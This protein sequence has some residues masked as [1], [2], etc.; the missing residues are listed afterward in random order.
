MRCR[1]VKTPDKTED[2]PR[3]RL[4]TAKTPDKTK[5]HIHESENSKK[6]KIK[7]KTTFMG[8]RL[9]R[10]VQSPEESKDHPHETSTTLL[11]HTTALFSAPLSYF[12]ACLTNFPP[13]ISL[14][15]KLTFH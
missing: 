11:I 1:I 6:P 13:M 5:G 9:V 10:T 3:E 12:H 7:V 2:R 14:L 15:Y 8:L 4:K